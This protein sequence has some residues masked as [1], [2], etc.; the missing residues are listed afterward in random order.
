MSLYCSPALCAANQRGKNEKL[1]KKYFFKYI[2]HY[3]YDCAARILKW[4]KKKKKTIHPFVATTKHGQQLFGF[5]AS[6][7][8]FIMYAVKLATLFR[9]ITPAHNF[10]ALSARGALGI[11]KKRRPLEAIAICISGLRIN[12]R[13]PRR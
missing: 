3:K 9:V 5:G 12:K 2:L 8:V 11:S 1:T 7:C 4:P 6:L 10:C 13:F